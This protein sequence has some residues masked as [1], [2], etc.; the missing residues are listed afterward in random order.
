MDLNKTTG[1]PGHDFE[2]Y[3]NFGHIGPDTAGTAR[4][5][6]KTTRRGGNVVLRQNQMAPKGL[7]M[8]YFENCMIT[9]TAPPGGIYINTVHVKINTLKIRE[10]LHH[11]ILN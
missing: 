11:Y 5:V 4:N 9:Y 7:W 3:L 2:K 1:G 8:E 6:H 10:G